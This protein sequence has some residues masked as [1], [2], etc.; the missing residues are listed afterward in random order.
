MTDAA[1][2]AT[3]LAVT[4]GSHVP[5]A[6]AVELAEL[7]KSNERSVSGELRVAIRR[8]LAASRNR[9]ALTA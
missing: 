9:G 5:A 7:A 2:Y 4:V 6:V 1:S 8:H 3:P